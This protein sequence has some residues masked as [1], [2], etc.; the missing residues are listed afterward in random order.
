MKKQQEKAKGGS[1]KSE[2][3]LAIFLAITIVAS[4]VCATIFALRPEFDTLGFLLTRFVDYDSEYQTDY[5]KVCYGTVFGCEVLTPENIDAAVDTKTLGQQEIKYIFKHNNE[6]VELKQTVFVV[7]KT[8][9]VITVEKEKAT[10]CLNDKIAN[11]GLKVEDNYDGE[12]TEKATIKYREEDQKVV[13]DVKDSNENL[14][15]Y[16][17]PAELGDTESPVI[18]LNGDEHISIY[19]N[20]W[21]S[22]AGAT[23]VD[24][25]DEVELKTTGS[26]NTNAVGAYEITYSATDN[27]GNVASVK[28]TV[29]VKQPQRASGTIY[30]T[31][32]DGPSQYTAR[33]L[34]ILKKYNVKATFF[35]T[36]R[37]DDSLILREHNEGHTVALHTFSH[38]YAYVYQSEENFFEDLYRIQN[39]VKNITGV[40]PTLIRFPGG[41]SNTISANYDGGQRIM[42]KLVKSVQEKG[43]T[44]FDWNVSSGD[45]GG[46]TTSDAVFNNVVNALKNGG[47]SV[48]LQHDIKGFS[49][50]AVERIIQY[51]L[52]R[53]YTFAPLTASSFTAHHGVNN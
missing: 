19:Q 6:V 48:V 33:L 30:L 4:L 26:V 34:D 2:I 23:V 28:R 39:R 1:K 42:S 11:F 46:A 40:A 37:G 15:T 31:F 32:D 3:F 36:G 24:N 44:Y 43:F 18:T 17:L 13:I 7:D 12:L 14:A 9:P 20:N 38:D 41:S 5:G 51:A 22:D 25:C 53:G 16:I 8:P 47:S 45:A 21:Y 52:N 35:V 27:S 50:D 29:E 49:V 10:I